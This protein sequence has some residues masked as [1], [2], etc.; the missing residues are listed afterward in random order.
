MAKKKVELEATVEE[1]LS[2]DYKE[3][4]WA[5]YWQVRTRCEKLTAMVD[6]YLAG[7]LDFEPDCPIQLLMTQASY[8]RM[9]MQVLEARAKI[10][11]IK[12]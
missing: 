8:M 11:K 9:Y 7:K 10:E 6:K 1:M 4:F 5:E 2:D 12:L 3:R